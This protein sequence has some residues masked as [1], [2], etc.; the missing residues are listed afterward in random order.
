VLDHAELV[1]LSAS[2][3][4]L[5]DE[6]GPTPDLTFIRGHGDLGSELMW[7]GTRRLLDGRVYREVGLAG[8]CSSEGETALLC[9]GGGSNEFMP[10]A[11]GIA[12]LRFERVIVL[13]SSFEVEEDRVREALVRSQ[14]TVFARE[15]ESF[16]LISGLCDARLAHDCAFYFDYSPYRER[17]AEGTLMAMRTDA[18][19][20]GNGALPDGNDDISRTR[21][22]LEEWL[23][24][25]AA[26]ERVVTDRA[27]VM[28]A[29]ALM[30]REVE[31]APSDYLNL[32]ALA[33]TLPPG[34]RVG[35]LKRASLPPRSCA[36]AHWATSTIR[37]PTITTT[38]RALPGRR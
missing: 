13:P 10:E 11:L 29:A 34:V 20:L 6:I 17:V 15:P 36:D 26:H 23:D 38:R 12:E 19:R 27:H 31:Y 4:T 28:I 2:R 5:L 21:A 3:R 1:S 35:P 33:A 24:A 30:G 18:E 7:E 32:P 8:M 16:R 9:G 14:A 25:I 37:R 22:T